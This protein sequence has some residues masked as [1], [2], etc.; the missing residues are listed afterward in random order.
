MNGRHS[1]DVG[2]DNRA[3]IRNAVISGAILG[4]LGF[5]AV[6][7]LNLA[8]S[9]G[10]ISA[11]GGMTTASDPLNFTNAYQ[12]IEIPN[13]TKAKFCALTSVQISTV[14]AQCSVHYDK[15]KKTWMYFNTQG[16]NCYTVCIY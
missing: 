5:V 2:T 12:E 14:G 11:L 1:R 15:A 13:S 8:T 9:G 6:G 3:A 16:S 7:L 10:V 4:V